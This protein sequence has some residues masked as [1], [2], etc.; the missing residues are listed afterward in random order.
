MKYNSFLK[1]LTFAFVCAFLATSCVKEGAPGIN[2]TPGT[3]GQNGTPGADGADGTAFC[4]NCHNDNVMGAIE[5]EWAVSVHATGNHAARAAS[6]DC[7]RCHAAEGFINFVHNPEAEAVGITDGTQITCEA[8]HNGLHV[9]FDVEND[10]EDFALRTT[11]PVEIIIDPGQTI[12]LNSKESNLCVN[13]HQV[14]D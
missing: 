13:C 11:G 9:T 3:N 4:L 5:T 14:R 6:A 12:D 8:C 1:L 10:G 2:G 7:A